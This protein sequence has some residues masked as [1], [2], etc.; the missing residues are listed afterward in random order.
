MLSD[1][2]CKGQTQ[3]SEPSTGEIPPTELEVED[4][5]M[6][7]DEESANGEGTIEEEPEDDLYAGGSDTAT[8]ETDTEDEKDERY[9]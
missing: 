6:E 5:E 8:T 2:K 9:C 3:E 1:C 4:Y 7:S